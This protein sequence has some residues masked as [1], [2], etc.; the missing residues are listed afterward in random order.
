MF[1]LIVFSL[2]VGASSALQADPATAPYAG[3]QLN[4]AQSEL[5]EARRALQMNDYP[6]ARR[7]AAQ[8]NLDARLAWGMTDSAFVRRD[9]L[10]LA[11]KATLLGAAP[12]GEAA[13]GLM[14]QR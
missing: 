2:L 3:G 6:L 4:F 9:A 11:R 14:M 7:L 1:R 13:P 5:D 8:A 12:L 10:E